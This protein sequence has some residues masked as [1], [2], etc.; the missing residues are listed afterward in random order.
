VSNSHQLRFSRF[1]VSAP[2]KKKTKIYKK[3]GVDFTVKMEQKYNKLKV[4]RCCCAQLFLVH[5]QLVLVHAH[6]VL[7]HAQLVLV[8]AQL[9]LVHKD[10]VILL[11]N[12]LRLRH[13]CSCTTIRVAQI[14][15][16]I[17]V[18]Q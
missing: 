4:C 13:S 11:D 9:V 10:P 3:T 14:V 12:T 17:V 1:S 15:V 16:Q 7:V 2:R 18:H 8:H 6:L 5:A